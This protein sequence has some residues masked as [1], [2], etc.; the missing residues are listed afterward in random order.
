MNITKSL[1]KV[2]V[3]PTHQS[4]QNVVRRVHWS[5]TFEEDG[6]TSSGF[7]ETFL[8]V[9]NL[10]SFIPANEV[11]NERVLQWAFEA[12]GGEDFVAQISSFHAEQIAYEKMRSGQ[13]EFAEGF[14][15]QAPTSPSG[16]P[17]Q[18]L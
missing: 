6:F 17:S 13:Q 15:L 3:L 10:Q 16:I 4:H 18:V 7:V 8:D 9:D 12:Q 11:G 5:I 2:F 1:F 14:E